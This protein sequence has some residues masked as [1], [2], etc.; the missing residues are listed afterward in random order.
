MVC[1]LLN[2][3]L[4]VANVFLYL[5]SAFPAQAAVMFPPSLPQFLIPLRVQSNI[6]INTDEEQTLKIPITNLSRKKAPLKTTKLRM[7]TSNMNIMSRLLKTRVTVLRYVKIFP[8]YQPATKSD[9]NVKY[10]KFSVSLFF[11]LLCLTV[12]ARVYICRTTTIWQYLIVGRPAPLRA[13]LQHEAFIRPL[14]PLNPPP[15]FRPRSCPFP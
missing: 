9:L 3:V 1:W 13:F 6:I 10:L 11:F 4:N 12:T 8:A 2:N 14:L 15:P 7:D 5:A